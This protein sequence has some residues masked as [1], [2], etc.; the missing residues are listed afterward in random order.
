MLNN[1]VVITASHVTTDANVIADRISCH[2]HETDSL[3]L[4]STLQQE[5]PLLKTCQRFHPSPELLS[6]IIDSL[7]SANGINP[8]AVSAQLR[9]NPGKIATSGTAPL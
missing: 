2:K 6:A 7:L 4:F 3:L 8:L 9:N 5:Y 1:P